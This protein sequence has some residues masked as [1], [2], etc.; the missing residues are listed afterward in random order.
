[1]SKHTWTYANIGGNTRVIIKDG[2]DIQHLAELDEKLW[3][4]L[5]C[6]V[7]GL[8]IPDESL[9][10]MD[11][12]GDSKIHIADVISTAEWLCRAL[13]NPQVLFE[14]RASVALT[15]MA[16]EA[17]LAVATPLAIDGI[18]TLDAVK[19]A[20]AGAS[21]E[22]QPA[23]EAPYTAD[24][25]AAYKACKDSYANYFQTAKLQALGLATLPA[26]A[27]VPGLSEEQFVEMGKKIA[28]Y[29]AGKAAAEAANAAAL[30]AA[31][32][33]YKPLE[34]LLLLCRDYVTL[35]R[36]FVSFQDFYAKR[37]K[38]LLGR[39]AKGESPWAIFQAGTLIIDQRACNLCLKVS[40]MAKHNTQATD[41]GM[42]LVYCNC[43]H[44]ATGQTMQ[45]VAAMTVGDI[46]NLKV[47]KNALFYD[48]QGQDWEAEVVKIIDNPISI[49]QAFWSP[50][51]KLGEWVSGLITK[52]AAEKEKKS[53]ADLTAKLQTPP[54]AGQAAAQPAPFDIA[55]F[56]GI[57]AA[58]GMAVGYIGSFLTS[59]ATGVKSIALTAWWALPVAIISL[60]LVISGPSMI[61]AWMKLRKRNLAPL[62]NANGWAIN[63]D[64]IVNVLFG[65]TLTEQAQYPLVKMK[66]P[67][68]K[69]KKLTAG[70]KW[71]I[72]I[73][74]LVLGIAIAVLALY[75]A[76]FRMCCCFV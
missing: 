44:H 73:A 24:V 9:Q 60:L 58:I 21:I 40:D 52:S 36:N 39:E 5:A 54:A 19:A 71:A 13:R 63:A 14:G 67:H 17:L 61:L 8:E 68:A 64:A 59:L 2:K 57:F 33:Q 28:D 55:K 37:G 43:K 29:E 41:S 23:P 75:C 4:V 47:G 27:A 56:A 62:L 70:G 10:C 11:N 30:A 15:D 22:A 72:A 25:I 18:V 66:D 65:N 12:N 35:L 31:K 26:D 34:K 51:R 53:F 42:F 20:I 1:M 3:A 69:I 32:A 46:R 7:S 16:D 38:A 74:A 48:R 50:Y 49:G 76:G 45:I 6:P